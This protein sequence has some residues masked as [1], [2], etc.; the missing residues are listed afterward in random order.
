M[1]PYEKMLAEMEALKSPFSDSY[2]L[3][4]DILAIARKHVP[5]QSLNASEEHVQK[6]AENEHA[7][8]ATGEDMERVHYIL[9]DHYG[10]GKDNA[11]IAKEIIAAMSRTSL[12]ERRDDAP[13]AV[14]DQLGRSPR[15][16]L[17]SPV[18][19]AAG[20]IPADLAPASPSEIL[21]NSI[22]HQVADALAA[23]NDDLPFF[24]GL[25]WAEALKARHE[26]AY[27]FANA[28]RPYLRTTRP[29]KSPTICRFCKGLDGRHYQ[30]CGVSQ[31]KPVSVSLGKCAEAASDCVAAKGYLDGEDVAKAVLDAA[32][33]KYGD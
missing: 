2:V 33:V 17:I 23:V 27:I 22:V 28:I 7:P 18:P 13:D 12:G 31:P 29:D 24:T 15:S 32:G 25:P 16:G 30:D 8:V 11:F 19:E 20:S 21:D 3:R 4:S 10:S 6:S 14:V 26:K 5:V 1:T 9:Q